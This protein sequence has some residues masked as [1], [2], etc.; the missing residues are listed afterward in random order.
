[1]PVPQHPVEHGLKAPGGHAHAHC[2][3]LRARSPGDYTWHE[4]NWD[5]EQSRFL[6]FTIHDKA[7][8]SDLYVAF[9]AHHFQVRLLACCC[10]LPRP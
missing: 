10:C 5:D 1:M 3:S 4:S 8:S 7:G 9:N 2:P 6:A